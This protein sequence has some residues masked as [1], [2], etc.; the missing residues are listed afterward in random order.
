MGKEK[1]RLGRGLASLVG[2]LTEPGASASD[3]A[4]EAPDGGS[5]AGSRSMI[6]AVASGVA[7]RYVSVDLIDPNPYQP[8][9]QENEQ[10][11]DELAASIREHGVVQPIVVKPDR[12][13][14]VLI[15]GQRRLEAARRCD[16]QVVPAIVREADDREMLELAL[17]ENIHREDLNCVD[18][19]EAYRR[20]QTSFAL[21]A[22]Q[23]SERLGQDRTTVTNYLRLLSLPEEV[24][25]LLR[26][27]R[28]SMGHARALAGLENAS[29]QIKLAVRMV[30]QG[31]S[32]RQAESL[33]SRSKAPH[34]PGA[35]KI[36]SKPANIVDL[37]QQ[38]TRALST[39]VQVNPARKKGTGKIVIEFYSLDDFDRIMDRICGEDREEL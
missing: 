14:Y 15:A 29:L 13:R 36:A 8:R 32:V 18:R 16:L 37:E 3:Q 20:Y 2:Q 1:P 39:K 21:S 10:A 34:G 23:I 35:A 22:E 17:V 30:Q 12:S 26:A 7:A 28:L 24:L 27:D 5:P 11:L 31:L 4:A 19:A 38:M 33:A 6:A 25:A 9:T